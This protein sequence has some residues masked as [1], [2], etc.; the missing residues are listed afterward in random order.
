MHVLVASTAKSSDIA[1]HVARYDHYCEM[2]D[3]FA[4]V[5]SIAQHSGP[6]D[7]VLLQVANTAE[8]LPALRNIRRRG[9]TMPVVLL[10][11]ASSPQEEQTAFNYGAD[12]VLLQ[13]IEPGVL[14]ARMQA[15]LRRGLGHASSQLTCGNVVLDQARHTVSVDGRPVRITSRE[16]DV[17]EMLMLRRGVLL[18]KDQFMSRAYGHEDEPD[19]RIL[20]VFICKLR[21]KLAAAGAPEIVRTIWGRGYV[22]ENPSQAAIA[23]ARARVAAGQPRT[24]RAHLAMGT[25][26]AMAGAF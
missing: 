13:P 17:L 2:A 3:C 14:I 9:L 7:I 8:A 25:S 18:T 11:A 16:F 10:A 21:R 5:D 20:D 6:Y 23:S 26:P 1:T 19:Q 4:E 22:L 15:I 12:D 24:R